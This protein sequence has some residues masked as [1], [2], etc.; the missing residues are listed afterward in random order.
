MPQSSISSILYIGLLLSLS[1]NVYAQTETNTAW[2]AY[3]SGLKPVPSESSVSA[4]LPADVAIS[5]PDA[6]VPADKARWSGQWHGWACPN[7]QCDIKVAIEA[8]SKTGATVVYAA[9]NARMGQFS[10]R[11]N[12]LF[13]NDELSIRLS[14]GSRLIMRLRNSE[15]MEVSIWNSD[16]RLLAA[17]VLT[18]NPFTYVRDSIRVPTSLEFDGKPLT[19]EAVTYKP[20]GVGP[21][22]TIIINHGSTK[23]EMVRHTWTSPDLAAFFTGAGWQVIFPQRRGRGKSD[24][25]YDEGY[26]K[27]R[28]EYACDPQIAL[29]GLEHAVGD[30]N[31]VMAHLPT[32][33]DVDSQ[34]LIIGGVSRGGV[35]AVV[36]ASAHPTQFRGVVNFVGGWM[37]ENCKHVDQI[38]MPMFVRGA[39]FDKPMIWLY[40][41]M[42]PFYS[43]DHSRKNFAAFIEAGGK[44][45]FLALKP[46]KGYS[47][48]DIHG[49]ASLWGPAMKE[50]LSNAIGR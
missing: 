22:P 48:H 38:N 14:T 27:D 10:E 43:L 36:Y 24:G 32:L 23:P 2:P 13:E 16:G 47:G 42:D 49:D 28:A 29:P 33:S 40:G 20:L 15:E 50:Y 7:W 34:R 17:G 46:P 31:A 35:L 44:G 12:G 6:K 30:L 1:G 25:V 11:A 21:F 5:P 8:V 41:D 3:I 4:T 45:S 39:N 9:A 19:L 26:K 37:D 18:M